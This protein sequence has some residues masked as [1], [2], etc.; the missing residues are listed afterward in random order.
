MF[1]LREK[2][3]AFIKY[4][5]SHDTYGNDGIRFVAV[6]GIIAFVAVLPAILAIAAGY[7]GR[8]IGCDITE[9]GATCSISYLQP[10]GDFLAGVGVLLWFSL[11]TMPLGAGAAGI[12]TLYN[13]YLLIKHSL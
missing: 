9:A 1:G 6:I 3:Y 11:I 4:I 13:I 7:I 8:F 5:F 10:V 12:W 2:Q